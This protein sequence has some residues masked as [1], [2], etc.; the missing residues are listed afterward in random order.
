M[1]DLSLSLSHMSN[2]NITCIIIYK[3]QAAAN[4]HLLWVQKSSKHRGI[5]IK[6]VES[7]YVFTVVLSVYHVF[8][9]ACHL[10]HCPP[11]TLLQTLC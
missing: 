5:K 3:M 10:Q 9:L 6:D 11:S 7:M 1:L 8:L 4:P 2:L